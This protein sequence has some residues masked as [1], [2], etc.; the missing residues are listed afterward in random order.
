MTWVDQLANT[1]RSLDT[2][3]AGEQKSGKITVEI[4][5]YRGHVNVFKIKDTDAVPTIAECRV[6]GTGF[7]GVVDLS[8][9]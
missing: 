6:N 5:L 4:H 8:A 7:T 2:A 1:L 3:M 9:K